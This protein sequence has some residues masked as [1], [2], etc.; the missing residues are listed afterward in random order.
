MTPGSALPLEPPEVV[1]VALVQV[2]QLQQIV[3]DVAESAKQFDAENPSRDNLRLLLHEFA[4]DVSNGLPED[5]RAAIHAA[6]ES[7]SDELETKLIETVARALADLAPARLAAAQGATGFAVNRRNN[8]EKD[9]PK[10]IEEGALFN[11][12]IKMGQESGSRKLEEV[13][14]SSAVP[15]QAKGA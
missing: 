8:P 11:G 10:L 13:P 14:P 12:A 15:R 3:V 1:R 6:I 9:V 5:I 2:L 4:H 7:Y